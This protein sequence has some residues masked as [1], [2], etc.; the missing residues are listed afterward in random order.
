ML[1]ACKTPITCPHHAPR[2]EAIHVSG[3]V[4][5]PR[6]KAGGIM[7]SIASS[8]SVGSARSETAVVGIATWPHQR[9][10]WRRSP[11][12]CTLSMAHVWR[13]TC[14][15]TCVAAREGQ[16]CAARR[17]Y[18][19]ID[20]P[21]SVAATMAQIRSRS[22]S[23][24]RVVARRSRAIS[25]GS[26]RTRGRHASGVSIHPTRHVCPHAVQSPERLIPVFCV[27][28]THTPAPGD[29][30]VTASPRFGGTVVAETRR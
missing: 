29:V 8:V 28:A 18:G 19:R 25:G 2:Q 20:R 13:H 16:R 4:H 11:V 24:S 26:R 7:A 23:A 12:A 5:R 3:T 10:T 21:A 9:E 14:G 15:V 22:A 1:R 27:V 17:T 6:R 30:C